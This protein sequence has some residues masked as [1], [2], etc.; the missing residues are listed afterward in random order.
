[1]ENIE[2]D[3][4][5]IINTS[6]QSEFAKTILKKKQKINVSKQKKKVI[7]KN[8]ISWF[9]DGIID[10]EIYL[11][12]SKFKTLRLSNFN[13]TESKLL[14]VLIGLVFKFSFNWRV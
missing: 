7:L 11:I 14:H 1:M 6:N 12:K 4:S 5:L 10:N 8:K 9:I 2:D 13:R 3:D